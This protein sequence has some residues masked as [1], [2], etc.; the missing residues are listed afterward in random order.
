MTPFGLLG[1]QFQQPGPSDWGPAIDNVPVPTRSTDIARAHDAWRRQVESEM[2]ARLESGRLSTWYPVALPSQ[3]SIV[4]LIG[5]NP[6]VDWTEAVDVLVTQ[7][8]DCGAREVRV[9][10]LTRYHVWN[11]QQE[12]PELMRATTTG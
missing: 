5:G 10:D 12:G 8:L 9:V 11:R 2:V 4:P 6:A 7:A 1:Y 3:L